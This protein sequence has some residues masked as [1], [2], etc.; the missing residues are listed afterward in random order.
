MTTKTSKPY[1]CCG[2]C[3][4]PLAPVGKKGVRQMMD[5]HR[6]MCA[7]RA[8]FLIK[9]VEQLAAGSLVQARLSRG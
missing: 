2:T 3:K 9:Q 4:R 7:P 5:D 8:G 6:Q 1:W